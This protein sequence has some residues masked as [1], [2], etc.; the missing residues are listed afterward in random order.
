MLGNPIV[1]WSTTALYFV[2]VFFIYPELCLPECN[3]AT[4]AVIDIINF[5]Y[6]IFFIANTIVYTKKYILKA[7]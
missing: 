5:S 7:K 2:F 4:K 6:F 3:P 1:M